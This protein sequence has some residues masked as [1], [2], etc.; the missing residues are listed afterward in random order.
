MTHH[1]SHPPL[2]DLDAI[3]CDAYLS[4]AH[5]T[6]HLSVHL[7][8]FYLLR[9]CRCLLQEVPTSWGRSS[10]WW[11]SCS[12]LSW[13]GWPLRCHTTKVKNRTPLLLLLYGSCQQP[14]ICCCH[15][16]YHVMLSAANDSLHS[17]IHSFI[18]SNCS[19]GFEVRCPTYPHL[20]RWFEAMDTRPAYQGIKSDYYSHCHDL[21]PQIGRCY[22]LPQAEQYRRRIDG[23]DW[24]YRKT[25]TDCF[26]PMLPRDERIAQEEVVREVLRNHE[27]IV[28]FSLRAGHSNGMIVLKGP[29]VSAPLAGTYYCSCLCILCC[30]SS[31]LHH[32]LLLKLT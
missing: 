31:T 29:G 20:L 27:A 24:D 16:S 28:R 3:R 30:S 21:P 11:T 12:H 22:S 5:L 23:D 8:I 26:E 18:R 2:R 17:L 14:I 7:S 32:V 13:R 10:R 15:P 4:L 6:I 25:P 9:S 1:P 19:A